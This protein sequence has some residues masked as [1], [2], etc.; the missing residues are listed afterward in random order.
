MAEATPFRADLLIAGGANDPNLHALAT[1]ARRLGVSIAGI[2]HGPDHEPPI[3]WD[4]ASGA[5]SIDGHPL[6]VTGGFLRYDV[7]NPTTGDPMR[8]DRSMAWYSTLDGWLQSTETVAS[9]N[10]EPAAAA[11]NKSAFLVRAAQAGLQVPRTLVTN[12]RRAIAAF[13]D[14]CVVKPAA[15]GAHCATFGE[16]DAET[17]WKDEAAPNPVFVQERLVYP[18][19]RAFVVGGALHMFELDSP[20]LDHRS[21][22]ESSLDY[23][24]DLTLPDG[25][26]EKLL[27]LAEDL[28][29]SFCAYDLKTR[30]DDGSL[31]VLEVNSGPM[32]AG[33][34]RKAGGKLTEAMVRA[35]VPG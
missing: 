8:V 19:F 16:V 22:R 9:F 24:P 18:E 17:E 26:G 1:A 3:S 31:C 29:L 6:E 4:F 27:G 35:L 13:G 30:P 14:G 28:G 11:G 10:P 33:F 12:D 5:L 21:T 25:I 32:F 20:A 23:R 15:G 7:F 2:F 34:D